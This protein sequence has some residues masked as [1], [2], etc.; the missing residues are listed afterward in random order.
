MGKL[1]DHA[2]RY[3]PLALEVNLIGNG[4]PAISEPAAKPRSNDSAPSAKYKNG[5]CPVCLNA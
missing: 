4:L 2:Q 3:T 5:Q 1:R